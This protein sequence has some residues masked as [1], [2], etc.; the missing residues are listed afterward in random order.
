M[1]YFSVRYSNVIMQSNTYLS[2]AY[3]ILVCDINS[4]VDFFSK[5]IELFYNLK[6]FMN[7]KFVQT[8]YPNLFNS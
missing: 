4:F 7:A 1:H 6:L 5:A 2:N 3:E 8:V